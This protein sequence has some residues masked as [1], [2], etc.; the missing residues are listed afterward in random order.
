MKKLGI[1][2]SGEHTQEKV[3]EDEWMRAIR[4]SRDGKIEELQ[5]YT[6][7]SYRLG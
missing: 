7:N 4:K 1:K 3:S 2:P 6:Y 5:G